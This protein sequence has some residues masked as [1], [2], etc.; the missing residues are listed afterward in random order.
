[1][2][3]SK[4]QQELINYLS[5]YISEHKRNRMEEVLEQRTRHVTVV[6][7]DIYK[8]HNASA[9]LRTCD[10]F[11]V[12][13]I[14][15]VEQRNTYDVNRYVT[16]GSAKWLTLHKYNHPNHDNI[17]ICFNKLKKE[18]Y[19][20][21][22]TSPIGD[23]KPNEIPVEEKIALVFGTE[24]SG[25]TDYVKENADGLVSI[26]MYGFTESLNISVAAGI[27]LD[28]VI[29]KIKGKG[30]GWKLDKDEMSKLKMEWYQ[31]TIKHSEPL[32]KNFLKLNNK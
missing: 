8:P 26:P 12:Q 4:Q 7:E 19:K 31:S 11:G 15:I 27:V 30:V 17:E 14:H 22:A 28:A 25:I 10:C 32:I 6:L 20:L 24:E 2:I 29:D 1:L 13:D 9:V 23:L 3:D 18:G 5:D 21:Y 16:R